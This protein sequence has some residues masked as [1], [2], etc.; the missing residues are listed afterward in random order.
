M[1]VFGCLISILYIVIYIVPDFLDIQYNSISGFIKT[2]CKIGIVGVSTFGLIGLISFNKYIFAIIYPILNIASSTYL[3]FKVTLGISMTAANVELMFV[4]DFNIWLTLITTKLI[5]IILITFI[6][7]IFI[8]IYRFKSVKKTHIPISLLILYLILLLIPNILHKTHI[9]MWSHIPFSFFY[10]LNDYIS[11]KKVIL[12][13]REKLSKVEVEQITEKPDVIFIIG[14][15]VRADHLG[16]NGYERTNT[17]FLSSDS[18]VIS[19]KNITTNFYSTHQSVPHILTRAD[20]ENEHL[21]YEEESFITLFKRLGYNSYWISNQDLNKGYAYFM[22]ETDSLK[23]ITTNR[24]W[25]NNVEKYDLDMLP[26]AHSFLSNNLDKPKLL[27]IHQIGSHWIYD[28]NYPDSLKIYNPTP[29]S[30]VM[31]EITNE[32]LINSYDNSI[33]AMDYFTSKLVSYIRNRNSILIFISDHG[34]SLGENGKYMHGFESNE[35]K[36]VACFFWYSDYYKKF[37]PDKVRN[38]KLNKDQ[39]ISTDF[40]FHT[41]IDLAGIKTPILK[42]TMSASFNNKPFSN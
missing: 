6:L 25:S 35:T 28:I 10:S 2:S 26:L 29:T 11:A 38:L 42:T 39:K 30:T 19:Y 31:S 40:I 23:L 22:N 4:N 20:K 13:Y 16:V 12:S 41:V 15:S 37:F 21:A 34:E 33:F 18:S 9:Y 3:Y 5:T 17:P 24:L 8:V 14:E 36:N 7:S 27:I 32:E 1:S